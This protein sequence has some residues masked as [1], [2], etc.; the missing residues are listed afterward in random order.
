MYLEC[1]IFQF[2]NKLF[3]VK[4]F[5]YLPTA[6]YFS[7]DTF[8][9]F[10]FVYLWSFSYVYIPIICQQGTVFSTIFFPL[11]DIF[12]GLLL[13][14]PQISLVFPYYSSIDMIWYIS[15]YFRPASECWHS[16]KCILFFFCRETT[17][18]TSLFSPLE[19]S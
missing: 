1:L 16:W 8:C 11:N 15:S 2:K 7:S 13:L 4:T 18:V 12:L 3:I 10:I 6:P 5:Q 19:T 14:I 17:L 9:F